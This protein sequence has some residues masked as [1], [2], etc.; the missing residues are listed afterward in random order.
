MLEWTPA[1]QLTLQAL[2]YRRW[3][4]RAEVLGASLAPPLAAPPRSGAD[5]AT[6][7]QLLAPRAGRSASAATLAPPPLTPAPAVP[8]PAPEERLGLADGFIE[9]TRKYSLLYSA[10][11]RCQ[12]LLPPVWA[13]GNGLAL[14]APEDADLLCR[15][16]LGVGQDSREAALIA[17]GEALRELLATPIPAP[18]TQIKKPALE[19]RKTLVLGPF[20][21]KNLDEEQQR[22][23]YYLSH[24]Q[25][26][27][28]QGRKRQLWLQI[29]GLKD[30][31]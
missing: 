13:D 27:R 4:R 25:F 15:A 9:L 23:V 21:F 26:V 10:R 24:P 31:S 3:L 6:F 11:L 12:W 29:L 1:Q 17:E 14:L 22:Q 5:L 20:V 7:D 19:G 8:S 30:Y 2:G 18:P 28:E 16:F